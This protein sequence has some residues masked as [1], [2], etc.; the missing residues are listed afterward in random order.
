MV[1]QSLCRNITATTLFAHVRYATATPVVETNCHPF[2]FGRHCFMHNG[3]VAHFDLIRRYLHMLL[4]QEALDH[5]KGTTDSETVAALYINHLGPD[6][7]KKQFT[8]DEMLG[9][10]TK[11]IADICRVQKE[12]LKGPNYPCANSLNLVT[13]DGEQLL[14]VRFINDEHKEPPSLY[15]S[16]TAGITLNRQY[17]GQPDNSADDPNRDLKSPRLYGWHVIVASEPTTFKQQEWELIDKNSAVLVD[18]TGRVQ[19]RPVTI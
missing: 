7:P 4:S 6:A 19:R 8:L 17:P 16:T 14:A 10:M 5:I 1:C 12:V 3:V 13:T 9:A 18:G 11:T 15:M 2:D